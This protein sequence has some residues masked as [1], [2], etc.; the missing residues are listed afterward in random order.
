MAE[1]PRISIVIPIYNEEGILHS[2]V[3]DLRERFAPLGYS[4]EIIL[5]ENGSRDRTVTIAQELAA[6]Y[7]EVRFFSIGEPNYGNALKKG[8]QEARG[9]FVICDEID[10]C[11]TDFHK[12]AIDLLESRAADMV[13]GS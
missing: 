4:Y 5:A 10:L 11:D 12:R 6:K 1:T 7:P 13:I 3:V 8:I 2:A 9:E